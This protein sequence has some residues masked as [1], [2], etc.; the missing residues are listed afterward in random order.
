VPT[1][2][3]VKLHLIKAGK[4]LKVKAA[5][6]GE[7]PLDVSVAPSGEVSFSETIVN[8]DET[9]RLCG[10]FGSCTHKVIAGGLGYKLICTE[11]EADE[12]CSADPAS[13]T[14]T[15][16]PTTTTIEV[17][18]TTLPVTTT[19]TLP[20][21][22]TTLPVT[23]T[24][25]LP[26]TTTTTL[27]VT[28]TTT[29]PVTT[30]T[31]LP[32]TTTTTL[33]VT[34]TTTLP[35]TTTTTLPVTTTT[36]LPVTTTTLPV[37]TTSTTLTGCVPVMTAPVLADGTFIRFTRGEEQLA[38]DVNPA[39]YSDSE[40]NA[41]ANSDPAMFDASNFI[42]PAVCGSTADDLNFHWQVTYPPVAGITNPYSLAGITGYRRVRLEIGG[43]TLIS[44]SIPPVNFKLIVTSPLT[45]LSTTVNILS[46]VSESS[47]S[48]TQYNSCKG[49]SVACPTC[50][51]KIAA[52]LPTSEAT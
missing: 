21:T 16:D 27:P 28:T 42:D 29:L 8:G 50:I 5:S 23:T 2:G 10:K 30:T 37:T 4:L 12:N 14:T 45:G 9:T 35:V 1:T 39:F 51:C 48:L 38:H 52:A 49:E 40:V 22:T 17:T 46:Q 20:V 36:T 32:V 47:L 25:T 13:S 34:T 44:Q 24:T 3:S 41:L 15:L 26:V 43:N 11:G 33:P 31:T 18:T 7:T 19:T 6:L